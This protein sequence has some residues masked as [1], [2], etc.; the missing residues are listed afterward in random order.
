MKGI[1]SI[2][3]NPTPQIGKDEFY[4]VSSFYPGTVVKDPNQIKWKIFSQN[5][6]GT[7]RELL[8]TLK[9]GNK[10]SFNFT[11]K[12]HGKKILI[13][14][15]LHNPEKKAPPGLI[16]SPVQGERKIT[17]LYLRDKDNKVF[18]KPPKYGEN[19][20]LN[21]VTQNLYKETITV[22]IWERDTV[23]DKGHDAKENTLLDT[24]KL[25]V[26]NV[27]GKISAVMPIKV[28]WRVKAQK[29]PLEGSTHEYYLVASAPNTKTMISVQTTDVEDAEVNQKTA[30]EKA[31]DTILQI[32]DN[33]TTTPATNSSLTGVGNQ[34][35]NP[36]PEAGKCPNCTKDITIEEIRKVCSNSEGKSLIQNETMIIAALPFLNKYKIKA[37]IDS[38]VTKAHFLAQLSQESKFYNTEEG[39]NYYWD[40]LITTFSQFQS[41]EGRKK[42][43]LWG[44]AVLNTKAKDYVPVT[45]ENEINIANWAY[46]SN[47]ENGDFNSGDG[48]LYR[49]R[50]FKQITWKAN[51]RALSTYFNNSM[52]IA[53]DTKVDWVKDV[54]K[55]TT[56]PS[57]AIISALAFWKKNGISALAGGIA[58]SNV[59]SVTKKINTA[60]KGLDAR[61]VFF[62]KAVKELKVE[63]CLGKEE[64]IQ[65]PGNKTND[66]RYTAK[67]GEVYINVITTAKRDLQGPLVVFDD[68]NI[69]FKT[70]SL[71]R[72]SNSNRLKAEGNGD[73][74]TGRTTTSYGKR[75][76]GKA[77]YGNHGLID[78]VGESGEFLTAT[79]NGRAG[80]AIHCGHTSGYSG[81]IVDTG[82]LMG[83]YGCIRIYNAE[84][85]KLVALYTKLKGEGKKIYCYI[86]DYNGD[87]KD[88]YKKY[89]FSQD[90]K[91]GSR[92][93]RSKTQ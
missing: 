1:K 23:S 41:T 33:V 73:T 39:F 58:D 89:G 55:L 3:G 72:G 90:P 62:K 59:K 47:L 84:M 48:S 21:I 17:H 31:L 50:G 78:L 68:K 44:R 51:Y 38:C 87:I 10:V 61:I 69:L 77:S 81:K 32:L 53:G 57:D 66:E 76:I 11:Q 37:G 40:S 85:E 8:G 67:P 35:A 86:E 49:G 52:L 56:T 18:S 30:T 29:G 80:I 34:N 70:H 60:L 54:K 42:A 79:K 6:N 28:A 63:A 83:T 82:K 64:N 71:C 4:E 20:R 75:H 19:I 22:G 26:E 12:W 24:F 7:W 65:T 16:V 5:T 25:K 15:Y 9:K 92:G 13:E 88:I 27:D 36:T 93:A 43:K 2:K 45:P 46:R 91:D 74:P 14:A